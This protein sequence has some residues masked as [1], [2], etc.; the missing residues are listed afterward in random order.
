MS[1]TNSVCE[2][3]GPLSSCGHGH[4]RP[5][6][7]GRRC[8]R[9]HSRLRNRPGRRRR[10]HCSCGPPRGHSTPCRAGPYHA[11]RRSRRHH[12]SLPAGRN[13]ADCPR[14][15]RLRRPASRCLSAPSMSGSL[16]SGSRLR[17][18]RLHHS[19]CCCRCLRHNAACRWWLQ[20]H[21][22][23]CHSRCASFLE[24]AQPDSLRLKFFPDPVQSSLGDAG[25]FLHRH[26]CWDE[27]GQSS[28]PCL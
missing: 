5:F 20:H 2:M 6:R 3:A 17:R 26:A 1:N 10:H 16:G 12:S 9:R 8:I 24:D 25:R 14:R 27:Q 18:N 11:R 7:H 13:P 15:R 21:S 22:G 23:C 28:S 19:R 4:R